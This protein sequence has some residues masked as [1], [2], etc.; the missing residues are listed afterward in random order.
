MLRES[1]TYA[2]DWPGELEVRCAPIST[3]GR[4]PEAKTWASHHASLMHGTRG[5]WSPR[6]L[7]YYISVPRNNVPT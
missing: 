6:N 3:Q 2:F 7:D 1:S 4:P 5:G